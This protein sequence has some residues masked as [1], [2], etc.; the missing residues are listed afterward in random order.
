MNVVTCASVGPLLTFV[1]LSMWS[2]TRWRCC[3]F[4]WFCTTTYLWKS[5]FSNKV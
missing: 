3:I 2:T 4:T 1:L 5:Y